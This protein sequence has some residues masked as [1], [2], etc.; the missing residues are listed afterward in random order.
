[1]APDY[2]AAG[3]LEGWE[4]VVED[5][6]AQ[7]LLAQDLHRTTTMLHTLVA[8]LPAGVF[9][10]Q[11]PTGQP[12]L[13]NNRAR[14][15]LGQREEPAASI[16]HWPRVYRIHRPDGT[17]YPWE[18]LPVYKALHLGLTTMRDD[19]VIHRPDGRQVPLITW[20]APIYLGP[21]GRIEAAVWVF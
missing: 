8:N 15:L 9:F 12:V 4:G 3:K 6:T 13:V 2:N 18:E 7:R 19:L 14:H 17:L 20:A 16:A 21:S 11:G 5:I 10:V 1:L